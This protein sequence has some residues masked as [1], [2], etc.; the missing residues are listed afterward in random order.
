MKNLIAFSFMV[1]LS[2]VNLFAQENTY[3]SDSS[4]YLVTKT[5]GTQYIGY[6][7]ADD[8]REVLILTDNLGKIYI[9]KSSINS[10]KPIDPKSHYQGGLFVGEGV[11]TTRY[12]FTT[13]SFPIKRGEHYAVINLYGPEVH[14][15]VTDRFSVGVMA[16][17]IASPI[18][19]ALKYSIPTKNE[20]LNFGLGTLIG[21]SGYLNQGRGFGGLHWAMA[22][23]G[24]RRNNITLSLGYG[25]FNSG[26]N[27]SSQ[28]IPAGTYYATVESGGYQY[29][30]YPEGPSKGSST[31]RAPIIGL[32]GVFAIND[33]VSFIVDVMAVFASRKDYFQTIEYSQTNAQDSQFSNVSGAIA[34]NEQSNNLVIMPGMRFQKTEKMS[35]QFSLAGVVGNRTS[36]KN[37]FDN[38]EESTLV[39]N[40]IN[41][42]FPVP[43]VSWFFKF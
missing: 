12:H 5:D 14:F 9:P 35:I 34:Y 30:N 19:L 23:Y 8:G 20:K 38:Q 36:K 2:T 28:I 13:N 10:I 1:F 6:I 7:L 31:H 26:N 37:Q 22:T 21:S 41:Y 24:D 40:K 43:M 33:K 29:F 42:S 15:S 32:A 11:F 4:K 39:L 25:Y 17:W 27:I 3:Y 18:A 16:T